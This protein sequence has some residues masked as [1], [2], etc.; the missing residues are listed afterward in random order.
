MA[1]RTCPTAV[2]RHNPTA[3]DSRFFRII[4]PE[5]L[6]FPMMHFCDII[7]ERCLIGSDYLLDPLEPSLLS[8]SLDSRGAGEGGLRGEKATGF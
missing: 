1:E 5:E 4:P 8:L 2:T 6:E 7:R 3:T